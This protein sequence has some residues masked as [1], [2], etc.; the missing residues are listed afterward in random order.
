MNTAEHKI[1]EAFYRAT[2]I[3]IEELMHKHAIMILNTEEKRSY[4]AHSILNDWKSAK[5]LIAKKLEKTLY[6]DFHAIDIALLAIM[7]S[8][9]YVNHHRAAEMISGNVV[10]N[11]GSIGIMFLKATRK[12]EEKYKLEGEL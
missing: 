6:E 11:T 9:L 8:A 1:L 4:A 7:R 2:I 3:C 5:P 12:L 10:Q